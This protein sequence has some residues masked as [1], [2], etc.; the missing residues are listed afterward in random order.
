[1][2]TIRTC[3]LVILVSLTIFC[4]SYPLQGQNPG[5]ECGCD[6]YDDYKPPASKSIYIEQGITVMEAQ[7][8]N[9]KYQVVVADAMPPNLVNITISHNNK[10]ILNVSSTAIGWG[11]SPD[12]DRFVMH[13][14][15]IHNKHWYI[16]YNLDPDPSVE[17]E[18]AVEVVNMGSSEVSSARLRFS[19]HGKYLLY[20]AI[21]NMGNLV[22]YIHDAVTGTEVYHPTA[23][24]VGSPSGESVAGWGFSPDTRDRTF[25]H[26]MLSNSNTY[27]LLVKNL[28]K[29]A[30]EY[31]LQ[32]PGNTGGAN[33][34]FSPCGDYF[35][36]T[37]E[38][39]VSDPTC[40]FYKTSEENIT[41]D[42]TGSGVGMSKAYTKADGHY[43]K[44]FN[45]SVKIFDNVADI[46][47][48]DT[49]PPTWTGASLTA[50]NITG[51]RIDLSWDAATNAKGT[52]Y[53]K[54]LQDGLPVKEIENMTQVQITGLSPETP[55]TF[56]I[57]AGDEAGN[58]SSDGPSTQATTLSDTPPIWTGSILTASDVQGVRMSLTWSG[59]SDDHDPE[60]TYRIFINGTMEAEVFGTTTYT[61]AGLDPA[62]SYT[63]KVEAGDEADQWTV[64][65]PQ[66]IQLTAGDNPPSWPLGTE[67]LT[68]SITETSL[69]FHWPEAED[70]W[71]V[72]KYQVYRD[73]EL[74]GTFQYYMRNILDED[75]EGGTVYLYEIKAEDEAGNPSATLSKELK[76]MSPFV[77][78]PLISVPG[79]QSLPDIDDQ[80]VVWQDT[81][82]GNADI[83]SYDLETETEDS[84]ITDINWQ[85]KPV[86]SGKS[87]VWA[88][89]RNGN[90][91]IYALYPSVVGRILKSICDDP[92]VQTIPE[93]DG[94]KIV[95]ADM[96]SGDW[97]IYMYDLETMQEKA[98]CTASGKQ[99]NPSVSGNIIVWEDH[100]H[101]NP[102]IYGYKIYQ[103]EEF[104]V[105]IDPNDQT[106]PV[107]D[108]HSNYRIFW[109]DNRNGNWDIYMWTTLLNS[110][111]IQKVQLGYSGNQTNPHITDDQLVYQEDKDGSV[112]I[113][114]YKFNNK[115]YGD[116]IPICT[117]DSDQVNP[118]TSK[119]RIVWEDRRNDGGDIYIW[120]R[121]PGTDLSLQI[122]EVTDP[123]SVGKT[124]KYI[125]TATNKGPDTEDLA[126]VICELPF[127]TEFSDT[128]LTQ[129]TL[130]KNGLTLTWALGTLPNDSSATLEIY[131]KTFTI[132]KLH[133]KAQISGTG[134]DPDPSNNTIKESTMVKLV[135]GQIIGK[136]YQPSMFVEPSGK[137]HVFF[138]EDDSTVYTYKNLAGLWHYTY[139]DT[140]NE[141][142]SG[143]ILLDE[144]GNVHICY[145]EQNW[146]ANPDGWLHYITN[147]DAGVWKNKVIALSDSGFSSIAMDIN[148][149]GSLHMLY[150]QSPG[151]AFH[152]PHKYMNYKSGQWSRPE[153]FVEGGY[154][155]IDMVLDKDGFA[156]VSYFW[157][158]QGVI[159]RKSED[160][161]INSWSASE[162][163][164]P[165][166][167]GGQMEGMILDIGLDSMNN[168][169]VVYP[170]NTGDDHNENIKYAGKKDGIW[171]YEQVDEGD[172]GSGAN[173]IAVEPSG[174]V[175]LSYFHFPTGEVR[176]A[177]NIAGPWIKQTIDEG[178]GGWLNELDMGLD[179]FGNI[180]LLYQNEVIKYAKR[181][182]INYFT[183]TP[184]SLDFGV[185]KV[186]SSA[187][188]YLKVFN[189][190]SKR[191]TIDSLH[192]LESNGF[193][194]QDITMILYPET[195]DSIA[196]EFSPEISMKVKTY[197]RIFF[198]GA[199][200]MFMDIPLRATTPVP[201]LSV[202]PD[203]VLFGYV[204]IGSGEIKT[205]TLTNSG[206]ADLVISDINVRYELFGNVYPTD[207]DLE[208]H[209]CTVLGQGES[210]SVQVSL[211]P[212]KTGSHTSYLNIY[213]NDPESAHKKVALSGYTSMRLI[214]SEFAQLDFG[215][216]DLNQT[217][218]RTMKIYNS[219]QLDLTISNTTLSGTNAGLFDFRNTC[220]TIL[221]GDS[222][223]MEIDFIPATTGDFSATLNIYSNSLYSNPLKV[224]L[225][226]NSSWRDLQVNPTNVDFGQ[227]SI[228]AEDSMIILTLSN[229]GTNDLVISN[230]SIIGADIY[231]FRNTG[232]SGTLTAGESCHDTIW[233]SPVFAGS[234]RAA[235]QVSSNDSDEPT[236]NIPLTGAAYESNLY[237]LSGEIF[238]EDGLVDI[239]KGTL[240]LFT[241][242]DPNSG[243]QLIV[244]GMNDYSFTDLI[245]ED[246]TVR[247]TP[248]SVLYPGGLPT[249]LGNVLTLAE[250]SFVT[251]NTDLTGQDIHM[252]N[253]PEDGT[254]DGQINGNLQE[255]EGLKH[256][257]VSTGTSTKAGD[258]LENIFAYLVNSGTG[259]LA[260][261]SVTDTAGY[262]EFTGLEDGSY[263]FIVDYQGIPMDAANPLLTIDQSN[264]SINILST[265]YIGKISFQILATGLED[266]LSGKGMVIYPN[267][268]SSHV[269]I[270]A[271]DGLFKHG[272]KRIYLHDMQG[273]AVMDWMSP[274]QGKGSFKI[275][276]GNIPGGLYVLT[277]AG[278]EK[279]YALRI[280]IIK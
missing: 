55:Y 33:F 10:S 90:S 136:G 107:V 226:G 264:D 19:P 24:I 191:I 143:D 80:L 142:Q 229:N 129:G 120:D 205:V 260:G 236:L 258:A 122:T 130:T 222:C 243:N 98:I 8:K 49:D 166:W 163:I 127:E 189:P 96:R 71:G 133:F 87:I 106:H 233:F 52:I 68:D 244:D 144:N 215:Y 150:Q 256:T 28:E 114:A 20:G 44:Y 231:E 242:G 168:P 201:E 240:Y 261:Y 6:T 3:P 239:T 140:I 177:T 251:A 109:Q 207:F 170:G 245:E 132:T 206:T 59:A 263:I 22:L 53:Y 63:L 7:S 167:A 116:V 91:D 188:K 156:H 208:G 248:D 249:Y 102:D 272:I 279:S 139:L 51:T 172:F 227:N 9:G 171:H 56:K 29:P 118:R 111:W 119:G 184:D 104:E 95:W 21:G 199:S 73:S 113:Y 69:A 174:V 25:V 94:T 4:L 117:A 42:E 121:P 220:T 36:W 255:E 61:L 179:V 57:E 27:T 151:A 216:Q 204:N 190:G 67:I 165:D 75:L 269:Y 35:L 137:V 17:G 112:D 64:D 60:L 217:A 158:N 2:K 97:D 77:E 230:T 23:L 86:V 194:I 280:V 48:D 175:H 238:D 241:S 237:S 259:E 78:V 101:G 13:G 202:T 74:I 81:R 183:I 173:A 265:V 39:A 159:Y 178:F 214:R 164:E 211:S 213:S 246:Y 148:D 108:V 157:I 32:A 218:T 58:W 115:F 200:Q 141:I 99:T 47:C 210:C 145:S 266:I 262:F 276:L 84:L 203:P 185:V 153:V 162:F 138:A 235:L 275:D 160:T 12:E 14:F 274:H 134:F 250:A 110:T 187:I 253:K 197:L 161:I 228:L 18:Q 5:V 176:Y 219:G 65:G 103:D 135:V 169:H 271:S 66:L 193:T 26:A 40:F 277:V 270:A 232:C 195:E 31:V 225:Y 273:K 268:A 46:P 223:E 198:N 38:D 131:L 89:A 149:M 196:V 247:F 54:I 125:L 11:F 50:G 234:K 105:C 224:Y 267:P 45:G 212:T 93:I 180:H 146:E 209:D 16:L 76:T 83:F 43:I 278:T 252:V 257:T 152:S 182:P 37:W 92:G 70:D 85:G 155:H 62:T 72:I 1:M 186:D 88:D 30:D 41:P 123:I 181:P 128:N 82:N 124:L 254:G 147:Q 221:P 126:K 15:D 154:D 79:T 192:V 34:R 100:R